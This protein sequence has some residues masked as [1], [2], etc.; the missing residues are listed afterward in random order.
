MATIQGVYVA[1]FGR[2]ADPTGLAYFNSVT[3]NGAN[4]SGINNLSGT[5]EYQARFTGMNNIQII[6]SIYQS[7][8][9]RDADLA[10]LNFFADAL[11]KGTLNINNIAIAILDG[12]QGNDKTI[13]TNKVAAADLYTKALDTGS[14]VVAYSGLGAAAQGRAFISGVSTT[15]PTQAAVDAA[16]ATMVSTAGNGGG[17][18]GQTY[19][20]AV[21]ADSFGPN[22][23]VAANKTT[24]NDDTLRAPT[25]NSLETVDVIDGGDGVDTLTASLTATDTTA[26]GTT[27][28]SVQ[29]VIK[30]VEKIFLDIDTTVATGAAATDGVVYTFNAADVTGVKE[31][32]SSGSSI[33]EVGGSASSISFTGV[34]L[35]TTVGVQNS[36]AAVTFAFANTSGSADTANLA[37]SGATGNAAITI[38]GVETLNVSSMG[39]AN[40]VNV[41]GAATKV[42]NVT[43]DKA[44]TLD[45]TAA[46]ATTVDA[47]ALKAG[48]TINETVANDFTVKGGTGNDSITI[49]ATTTQKATIE[50]GDGN[51]L[52]SA[53]ANVDTI[54][55]GNGN[56]VI[57]GG[58]AGDKIT[59]GAG[60]DIVVISAASDST[61]GTDKMD[62]IADFV[63]G[64]DKISF[65]TAVANGNV[66]AV[67]AISA[68]N[69]VSALAATATLTDAINAIETAIGGDTTI[70]KVVTFA[71][72]GNTYVLADSAA[73]GF[74]S[75]DTI[76]QLTGNINIT[77]SDLAF[78]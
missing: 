53:T 21:G 25:A 41:I 77:S 69:A 55:G 58:G 59:L 31:L 73:E 3:N 23:A 57:T 26:A 75:T 38:A 28:V 30:N 67:S 34:N 71:F 16:V 54:N 39:S 51:D 11:A 27:A 63:A 5:A 4:L 46:N 8:F 33:T 32:W 56:D 61:V 17:V 18:V 76:V 45:I 7:L 10:G 60:N 20:L 22:S 44:L 49:V 14:E 65:A 40:S 13:V 43:G 6:N 37:L 62:V 15:V 1:L 74:T 50:G 19:T 48:L 12:A 24:A 29:P 70:N 36:S 2:P 68:Q 64:T 9:G 72:Q 52:I 78:A 35:A 47:S 66:S 42:F